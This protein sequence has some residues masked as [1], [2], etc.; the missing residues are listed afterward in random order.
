MGIFIRYH[1]FMH[2][3]IIFDC[4]HNNAKFPMSIIAENKKDLFYERF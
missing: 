2:H 3:A 1:D 4:V